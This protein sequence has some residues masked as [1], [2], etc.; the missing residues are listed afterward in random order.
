MSLISVFLLLLLLWSDRVRAFEICTH[1]IEHCWDL[2]DVANWARAH[3]ISFA[4]STHRLL[5]NIRVF[6]IIY[7]L[8]ACMHAVEWSLLT[9]WACNCRMKVSRLRMPGSDSLRIVHIKLNRW[10]WMQILEHSFS[11]RI[12][13]KECER[14]KS[15][16]KV[17]AAII[18]HSDWIFEILLKPRSATYLSVLFLFI[19]QFCISVHSIVSPNPAN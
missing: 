18:I 11:P 6:T 7:V 19:G 5:Q 10:E 9:K 14:D 4:D 2:V 15:Y 17:H 12:K 3:K 13:Q 1:N 8:S 16:T